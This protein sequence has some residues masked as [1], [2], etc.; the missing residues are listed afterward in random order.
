MLSAPINRLMSVPGQQDQ[1]DTTGILAQSGRARSSAIC[2]EVLG[3]LDR[4][5]ADGEEP[6]VGDDVAEATDDV[7]RQHA[8]IDALVGPELAAFEHEQRRSSAVETTADAQSCSRGNTNPSTETMQAAA[9]IVQ[10]DRPPSRP[11]RG[12]LRRREG[13]PAA[14]HRR[15]TERWSAPRKKQNCMMFCCS[16][17]HRATGWLQRRRAGR[18]PDMPK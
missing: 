12:L 10:I 2:I 1:Q 13:V 6:H 16:A 8:E 4:G 18:R 15:A 5:H 17:S 9:Y 14:F 7:E 3:H 11:G